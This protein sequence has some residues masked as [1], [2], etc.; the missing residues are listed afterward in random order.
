MI[1][2][3]GI[4]S[5]DKKNL[6]TKTVHTICIYRPPAGSRTGEDTSG[7]E[8]RAGEQSEAAPEHN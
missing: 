4:T 1:L 8:Q 6:V 2:F 3:N 7:A 5:F